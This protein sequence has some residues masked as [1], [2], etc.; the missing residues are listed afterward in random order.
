M[1]GWF[2]TSHSGWI[3]SHAGGY[4]FDVEADAYRLARWLGPHCR[5]VRMVE[6]HT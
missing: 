4:F 2:V 1:K 5:V 6:E 3:V